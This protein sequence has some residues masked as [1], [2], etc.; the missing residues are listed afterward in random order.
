MHVGILKTFFYGYF[1]EQDKDATIALK[2][3][4]EVAE[5]CSKGDMYGSLVTLACSFNVLVYLDSLSGHNVKLFWFHTQLHERYSVYCSN[6]STV[7]FFVSV[8]RSG[9]HWVCCVQRQLAK[10]AEEELI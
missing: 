6:F 10:L 8:P 7:T 1:Y 5:R 4:G 9:T 2:I 3:K